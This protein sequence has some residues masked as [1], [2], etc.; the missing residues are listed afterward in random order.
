LGKRNKGVGCW[1]SLTLSVS[2]NNSKYLDFFRTGPSQIAMIRSTSFSITL[3][4]KPKDSIVW[5]WKIGRLLSK[6]LLFP[7]TKKGFDRRCFPRFLPSPNI[8][9][10]E[11]YWKYA[12]ER[13][14]YPNPSRYTSLDRFLATIHA[15]LVLI[16]AASPDLGSFL[17]AAGQPQVVECIVV[18]THSSQDRLSSKHS[19]TNRQEK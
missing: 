2:T 9:V 5:I 4:W 6:H 18:P 8:M 3:F 16:A 12:T 10:F 17:S 13:I 7:Y 1:F 15:V 14:I 19:T 11:Y